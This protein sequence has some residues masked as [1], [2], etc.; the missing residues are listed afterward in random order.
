MPE[1]TINGK[2][3]T[4]SAASVLEAAE[5]QGIMIPTLCH[6]AGCKIFTSCMLCMVKDTSAGKMIP[7]CS[8]PVADGMNIETDSDEVREARREALELLLSEHLGDCEAPC[9]LVCPAFMD[10]PLM[11]RQ[12]RDGQLEEAIKTVK[13]HIA[14]PAVLGR[15]CPAPCEKACRRGR[16]DDA[17]SICLLE[18]Y[19]ADVDLNSEAPFV[20]E[21]QPASGKKI[22]II[23]AGPAGL[24]AT[25]YLARDGHACTIYEKQGQA[26]GS[27]L[28]EK[29]LPPEVL[30]AELEVFNQLGIEFQL[31]NEIGKDLRM[32][33]LTKDYDAVLIAAGKLDEDKPAFSGIELTEEGIKVTKGEFASSQKGV[34]AAGDAVAAMKM[35]V[36]AV[37]AGREAALAIATFLFEGKQGKYD[38]HPGCRLTSKPP[39]VPWL[40]NEKTRFNS[41]FGKV[42]PEDKAVFM[43]ESEAASRV[44]MT[45]EAAGF[46]AD[47][48][49][50]E[51]KRCLH[52][53]CRKP[54]SCKL[55]IYAGEYHAS[56][57]AFKAVER[58]PF[59]KRDQHDKVIYEPGK[60]IKCGLCVRISA[61]YKDEPG[62]AFHGRGSGTRITVPFDDPLATG[63][64][65]CAGECVE[66]CPTG[67]L[68]WKKD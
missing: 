33:D 3:V 56:A 60:C 1:L 14:L 48:A 6:L 11:I 37:G 24:S 59:I 58:T 9:R 15:I 17:V 30:Q 4:T 44:E 29:K 65:E 19:V 49:M 27:L 23:G 25:Y 45:D 5:E 47:E 28:Q 42:L 21:C 31:N 18:R 43:Q 26:G 67:A 46:T 51:A 7:A 35:A 41:R 64:K 54:D 61:K 57:N 34:F 40:G 32:A 66:A 62:F 8:V 55:R 20:P 38:K 13:Q 53:D 52:C 63:V 36:H 39:V 50:S 16:I 12:I 10:I 2:K 68:A 22:A